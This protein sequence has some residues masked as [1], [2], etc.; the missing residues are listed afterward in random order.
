MFLWQIIWGYS[1]AELNF[2]AQKNIKKKNIKKP[3]LYS[4]GKG[5]KN[6]LR[7][8]IY[9]YYVKQGVSELKLKCVIIIILYCDF[10]KTRTVLWEKGLPKTYNKTLKKGSNLL[11]IKISKMI[12]I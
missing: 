2:I 6:Y 9:I 10:I 11:N 12:C 1:I 7:S 8:E 5:N 4:S 3:S